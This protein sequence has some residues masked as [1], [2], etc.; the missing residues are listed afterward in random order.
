MQKFALKSNSII[1]TYCLE[2][3]CSTKYSC[4]MNSLLYLLQS[5]T[6]YQVN[7]GEFFE[8]TQLQFWKN[9]I[10]VIYNY[11][12]TIINIFYQNILQ[13]NIIFEKDLHWT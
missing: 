10:L 6:T 5:F 12:V 8:L 2:N 4:L 11:M 9:V 3:I 1:D 7:P 13:E